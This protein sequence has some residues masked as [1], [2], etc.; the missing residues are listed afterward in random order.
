MISAVALATA[1]YSA[2]VLL[3]ET[4]ACLRALQAIKL[5]PRN[6]ACPPWIACHQD[7][8]PNLHQKKLKAYQQKQGAG[9]DRKQMYD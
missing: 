4:V 9:A 5:G 1:L 3:R 8:Q 6:T 7:F 2:S